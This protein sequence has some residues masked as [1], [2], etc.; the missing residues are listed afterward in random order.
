MGERENGYPPTSSLLSL[1][2]QLLVHST[3]VS[4]QISVTDFDKTLLKVCAEIFCLL[5]ADEYGRSKLIK[6]AT[7]MNI[8]NLTRSTDRITQSICGKTAC[9]SVTNASARDGQG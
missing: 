6:R 8:F 1:A 3:P 9:N 2:R 4:V 5:S 7:L